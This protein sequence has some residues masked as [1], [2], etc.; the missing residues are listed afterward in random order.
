MRNYLAEVTDDPR[1]EAEVDA[2]AAENLI[3]LYHDA[4]VDHH[5]AL[6]A[7]HVD[8]ESGDSDASS[9]LHIESSLRGLVR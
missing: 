9:S 4:T 2:I 8:S 5:L 1:A 3:E 6:I 7:G